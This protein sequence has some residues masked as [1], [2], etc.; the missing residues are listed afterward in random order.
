MHNTYATSYTTLRN[1]T[2]TMYEDQRTFIENSVIIT[3]TAALP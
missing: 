3:G 2:V 1:T